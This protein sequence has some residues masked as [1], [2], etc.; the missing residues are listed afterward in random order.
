GF[1][2]DYISNQKRY[3]WEKSLY[4][5]E[6]GNLPHSEKF[7][8]EYNSQQS[9]NLAMFFPKPHYERVVVN[10]DFGKRIGMLFLTFLNPKPQLE[11]LRRFLQLPLVYDA[12]STKE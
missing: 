10:Q 4:N 1:Q 6:E 3:V 5:S 9:Y 8:V 12:V 11:E 7:R 2:K